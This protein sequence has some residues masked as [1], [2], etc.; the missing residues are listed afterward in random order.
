MSEDAPVQPPTDMQGVGIH[1]SYIR[2][3]LSN[4]SNKLDSIA[5][6]HVAM[7]E[8]VHF[9]EYVEANY[10]LKSELKEVKEKTDFLEKE[11]T[12]RKTFQDTLSGKMIA[13]SGISGVL[14][15]AIT[16]IVN[17]FWH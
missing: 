13:W 8:Y 12:D 6:N 3:D 5:N 10:A 16:L 15:A 2:R 14:V 11:N 17:H 9:K 4:M 7:T 1:L